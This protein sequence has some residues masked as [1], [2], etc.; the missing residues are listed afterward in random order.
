MSVF[1]DIMPSYD[2]NVQ[3]AFHNLRLGPTDG[4]FT[5]RRRKRLTPLH[6]FTLQFNTLFA[7]D[8]KTLY[9]FFIARYGGWDAFAFF[10]C[11][12]KN[13]SA[14]SIGTGDGATTSFNL[15]AKETSGRT[16]F[17]NSVAQA[18][19]TDYTFYSGQGTDGQDKI[20]FASAPSNSAAITADLTGRR[21][22]SNCIFT[23]DYMDRN[24]FEVRLYKTGLT[25]IEVSP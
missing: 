13:W 4:D 21:Y 9:D 16:V 19:G 8:I 12:S 1:P 6:K 24:L 17:I 11:D 5:Q 18:E 10:D 15:Q 3:S 14:L 20:T 2:Y 7:A 23:D 22:Y 25:I